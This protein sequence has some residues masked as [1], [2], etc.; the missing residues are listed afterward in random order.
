MDNEHNDPNHGSQRKFLK[1]N[2]CG[3]DKNT[4]FF[5]SIKCPGRTYMFQFVSTAT[6]LKIR[7]KTAKVSCSGSQV[8]R[9]FECI[10]CRRYVSSMIRVGYLP[11]EAATFRKFVLVTI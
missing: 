1:A 2:I 11:A 3:N 9:I 5:K 4:I 8:F 10:K 6:S 7:G